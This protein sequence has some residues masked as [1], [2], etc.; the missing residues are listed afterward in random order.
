MGLALQQI[1][2][3]RRFLEAFP[4]SAVDEPS[5]PPGADRSASLFASFGKRKSGSGERNPFR[6]QA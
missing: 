1:H 6:E 3:R 4:A 2:V 5:K